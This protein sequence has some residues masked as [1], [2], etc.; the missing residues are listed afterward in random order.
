MT[1]AEEVVQRYAF[2][3]YGHLILVDDPVFNENEGCYLSNLRSDYPFVIKDDKLPDKKFVHLLKMDH[4]GYIAVS[5]D[6][7]IIFEK[8]T[9]RDDCIKNIDSFFDVWKKRTEQIVISASANNLARITKFEHFF[10]PIDSILLALWN[11]HYI[12]DV[13]INSEPIIERRN[14]LYLYLDL[15]EGLKVIRRVNKGYKEGELSL[16][17]RTHDKQIINRSAYRNL[18]ISTLIRERYTTLRDVFKLTIFERTIHLDNCIYLPEIEA[19]KP[20]YRTIESLR[21]EYRKYYGQKI[22]KINAELI[23]EQLEDVNAIQHDGKHYF[24]DETL[25]KNM[26]K[27][28]EKTPLSGREICFR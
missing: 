23:L 11:Y 16:F 4:L 9:A 22:S 24:G 18:L 5:K 13:E 1:I 17:I 25:R 28:K 14:K 3:H 10:E 27:I 20:V 26:V 7:K 6:N 21:N 2:S 8:T 15:L 12:A 19:E